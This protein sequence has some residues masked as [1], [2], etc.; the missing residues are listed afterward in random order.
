MK[1]ISVILAASGLALTLAAPAQ[2]ETAGRQ[3]EVRYG[4]LDLTGETGAEILL[5]RLEAAAARVCDAGNTSFR[6]FR[7]VRAA[8]A[9]AQDAL[10][11]AVASVDAPLVQSLH[12]SRERRAF[13]IVA[14]K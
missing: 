10:S 1:R 9:C 7:A 4:D 11:K 2:A 8:R 6:D 3:V 5:R 12:A 14:M 13:S